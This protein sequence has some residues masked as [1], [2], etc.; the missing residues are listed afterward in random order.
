MKKVI[1]IHYKLNH[2]CYFWVSERMV[3]MK[4]IFHGKDV[5]HEKYKEMNR[6]LKIYVY[7]HN[8]NGSFENILLTTDDKPSGNYA[9]ESY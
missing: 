2:T 5:L 7:P 4:E 1:Y 9:S 8:K 3:E 6:S